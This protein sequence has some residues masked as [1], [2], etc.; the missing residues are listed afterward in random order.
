MSTIF[1][2]TATSAGVA[3]FVLGAFQTQELEAVLSST[4]SSERQ[5]VVESL[6]DQIEA[7]MER[8]LRTI[9][10]LAAVLDTKRVLR[11][12]R[13]ARKLLLEYQQR[14]SEAQHI[15][16]GDANGR[17]ITSSDATGRSA[18]TDYSK[19][20]YFKKVRELRR[21]VI[22][23][24][25]V[26]YTTK[27]RNVHLA[28]PLGGAKFAGYVALSLDLGPLR[29]ATERALQHVPS[30]RAIVFDA[31]RRV[32]LDTAKPFGEDVQILPNVPIYTP[33]M[34]T[35]GRERHATIEG[36]ETNGAVVAA[37]VGQ[38]Q[39]T[40]LVLQPASVATIA[41]DAALQRTVALAG[42]VLAF[43]LLFSVLLARWT[44]RPIA[45]ISDAA[46]RIGAN[47][48]AGND[49]IPHVEGYR[50]KEAIDLEN[51]LN[52][53]LRR[54]RAQTDQ[55]EEKVA[56]RT[57]QLEEARVEAEE[58]SAHKSRF[59]ANMSH[60]IRT[61]MN[62]VLGM[63]ELLLEQAH[64]GELREY[65]QA[66]HGSA[67][68]LLA[69]LNDILDFSKI[70]AGRMELESSP[71]DLLA[72]LESIVETFSGV[73]SNR[74]F[75]IVLDVDPKTPRSVVGDA[76][77]LR[78]LLGNLVGNA[79][80]FTEHGWVRIVARGKERD[81]HADIEIEIADTG[82]GIAPGR[83]ESIF[84]AF[85]QGDAST[86]RKFGGT[87]LGLPIARRFAQMMGG[88]VT[89][90]SQPSQGTTFTVS[91]SLPLAPALPL[92]LRPPVRGVLVLSPHDAIR[93]A[94][95][96]Q[97]ALLGVRAYV[98]H[99]LEETS[100]LLGGPEAIDVVLVDVAL[101]DAFDLEAYDLPWVLWTPLGQRS[102]VTSACG[103]L[104]RPSRGARI[105]EVLAI[106]VQGSK[107]HDAPEKKQSFTGR[108]L[109]VDDNR[110]NQR[111]LQKMLES[112]GV[113]VVLASDGRDAVVRF[114]RER[115]DLVLMDCQMPVMDG[116]EATQILRALEGEDRTPIV[117]LT[118]NASTEDRRACLDAGMDEHLAKPITKSAL[119]DALE[120]WLGRGRTDHSGGS[121]CKSRS[122]HT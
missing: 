39:W 83:L 106:A 16:V 29:R 94:A 25:Q 40:I 33:T 31:D 112:F 97:L 27:V 10:G 104:M 3:T 66:A 114:R 55:L 45:Q 102:P 1:V 12:D 43:G 92:P 41:A 76:S 90:A 110:V 77:R 6:A 35:K 117:A 96:R 15:V 48:E 13:F 120:R 100:D 11:N 54:L 98:A 49:F 51:A 101:A 118:A 99:D 32:I 65:A 17:G 84:D 36:V 87:G 61:P 59:I 119:R 74:D 47:G 82:I 20:D 81:G 113:E 38:T 89:V 73:S 57:E 22:S 67:R 68:A 30:G 34:E 46:E 111:V 53:M 75:E 2:C 64:E 105:A 44:A 18:G 26:G 4:A 9:E 23:R 8:E 28:A 108:V 95:V 60:E 88:D 69:L 80:K 115:F 19:R 58:A 5:L 63:T 21:A 78:Q 116:Y 103:T 91:V 121:V 93:G 86:T 56:Q 107:A 79:V 50:P 14:F 70:D 122:V 109:A 85:A 52:R 24:P 7:E 62:G 42:V 71:F 37:A 72:E